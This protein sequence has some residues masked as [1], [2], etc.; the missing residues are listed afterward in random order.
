MCLCM[1]AVCWRD[2]RACIGLQG[3]DR[4]YGCA[5]VAQVVLLG[6]EAP[7]EAH[8]AGCAEEGEHHADAAEVLQR[9]SLHQHRR[10]VLRMPTVPVLRDSKS[11]PSSDWTGESACLGHACV[12]HDER[13]R[14]QR[15][16]NPDNGDARWRCDGGACAQLNQAQD[17]SRE[18]QEEAQAWHPL[19]VHTPQVRAA[20]LPAGAQCPEYFCKQGDQVVA[21]RMQQLYYTL[22]APHFASPCTPSNRDKDCTRSR[23]AVFISMAAP[24]S[25]VLNWMVL[26]SVTELSALY[27]AL[28]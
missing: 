15:V 17:E 22:I 8:G 2:H 19:H 21:S 12:V 23:K 7:H 6:V 26:P 24:L 11:G 9:D 10:A 20:A 14:D 5:H 18:Q 13:L 3:R 1:H 16:Y 27:S 4:H 28:T 25:V